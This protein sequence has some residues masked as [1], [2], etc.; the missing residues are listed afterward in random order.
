[1]A[2]K[3]EQQGTA[4]DFYDSNEAL[5]YSTC[6]QTLQLQRELTQAAMQLLNLPVSFPLLEYLSQVANSE[7]VFNLRF[8]GIT[9]RLLRNY[10][11][12]LD[13]DQA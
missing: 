8:P 12:T 9:Y 1:M 2:L 10:F 6:S 5:R 4:S 13:V 11:W 7:Q 3:P